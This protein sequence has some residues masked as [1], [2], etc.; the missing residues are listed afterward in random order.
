VPPAVARGL[1]VYVWT[2]N[3]PA[4]MRELIQAGVSGIITDRPDLLLRL[5]EERA[6]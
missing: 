1:K 4:R 2:V 6:K 3:D 5:R